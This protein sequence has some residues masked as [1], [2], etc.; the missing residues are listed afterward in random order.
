MLV[1]RKQRLLCAKEMPLAYFS[2]L[3]HLTYWEKTIDKMFSPVEC[4]VL[5]TLA[6]K[7]LT[8]FIAV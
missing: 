7:A 5:Y 1:R 3:K 8:F 4:G 6:Q 2:S